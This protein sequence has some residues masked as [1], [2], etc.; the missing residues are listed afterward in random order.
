MSTE[1][2]KRAFRRELVATLIALALIALVKV[3]LIAG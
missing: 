1:Q 2:V 3:G